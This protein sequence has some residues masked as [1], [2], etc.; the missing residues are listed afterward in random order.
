LS[1]RGGPLSRDASARLSGAAIDPD[2][3]AFGRRDSVGGVSRMRGMLAEGR[4]EWAWLG[5]AVA[6]LAAMELMIRRNGLAGWQTVPFHFIYVSF[7]ILYGFRAWRT[8]QTIAGI[9]FVTASTG[10]LTLHAISAGREGV[11]ELTEVPLMT[12]M[13]VAMVYHVIRRQQATAVAEKLAVERQALLDREHAFLSDASHELMTPLTIARGHLELLDRHPGEPHAATVPETRDLVLA[14]LGRMER[15]VDRLLLVER[16]LSPEFLRLVPV[17]AADLVATVFR[18][19]PP[20]ADRRWVLEAVAPGIVS[21][22]AD[23]L[24]QALDLVIENAVAFTQP[25]ETIA[26]GS[27]ARE[28]RLLI[29]VRDS[30]KGI[31]PEVLPHIF[32][33]FFRGDI[34]RNRRTGGAGLGLSVARA[35]VRAHGGE[36]RATSTPGREATF[37][38][39]LPGLGEPQPVARTTDGLDRNRRVQLAP[40]PSDAHVHNV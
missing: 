13:F 26:V 10:I 12:L 22:D 3:A 16:A 8:K 11:P 18:R 35:V 37:E 34:G 38:I 17:D 6:N 39:A 5:F 33:R 9:L 28:G 27:T 31:D 30:G 24:T 21:V 19:W 15:I 25:G 29:Q 1:R 32:E 20:A 4:P 2:T 23:Q 7:T 40:E 36:I 14:E